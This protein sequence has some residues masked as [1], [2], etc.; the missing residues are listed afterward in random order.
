[1]LVGTFYFLNLLIGDTRIADG[2]GYVVKDDDYKVAV[3]S[4]VSFITLI[5]N[6]QMGIN[7]GQI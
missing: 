2:A 1:L 5:F 6:L 4:L 3:V 7:V